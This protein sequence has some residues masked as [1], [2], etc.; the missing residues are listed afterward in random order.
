MIDTSIR[1]TPLPQTATLSDLEAAVAS[2]S[3]Q[4]RINEGEAAGYGVYY[5]DSSYD[6]MQHLKQVGDE[7]DGDAVMIPA[8]KVTQGNKANRKGKQPALDEDRFFKKPQQQPVLPQ[9][10]LPSGFE[11]S[12]EEVL[13]QQ[14]N[15]P[16]DLQ[17]LQPDMDP[18]LRQVLE[19]LEDEAFV[20]EQA[21]DEGWMNELLGGGELENGE[22]GDEW[23]FDEDGFEEEGEGQEQPHVDGH[24]ETWEDR[25]RS[26]KAAGGLKVQQAPS[27]DEGGYSEAGDTVGSLPAL[28]VIGGKKRRKGASD[29]SGYS[30]SS[31]S[32]FRNKGL[33][34]LDE[35]FDKVSV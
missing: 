2:S 25:F 9:S 26:F 23:E 4:P 1:L 24:E 33:S 27:A 20:D 15:V 17:G 8:P 31:S 22:Q 13:A 30:M 11:I 28:G 10:V 16:R 12:R 6:Y 32:M 34:T 18:H 35:M 19:A 21:E 7:A 29:A 14:A 3:S 5:D